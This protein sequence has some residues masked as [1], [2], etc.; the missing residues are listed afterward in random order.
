LHDT[1]SKQEFSNFTLADAFVCY[2]NTLP[3]VQKYLSKPYQ[4]PDLNHLTS[5]RP[6]STNA[7]IKTV[8]T[9]KTVNSILW[10]HLND[11]S[12][13]KFPLITKTSADDNIYSSKPSVFPKDVKSSSKALNDDKVHMHSKNKPKCDTTSS[14]HSSKNHPEDGFLKST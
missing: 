2:D 10:N 4:N 13:N 11:I 5:I 1:K 7:H 9:D 3:G 8:T 14:K 6:I 12:K